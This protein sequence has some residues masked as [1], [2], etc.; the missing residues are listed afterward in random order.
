MVKSGAGGP[1]GV[2]APDVEGLGADDPVE[3]S[4]DPSVEDDIVVSLDPVGAS[5][6]AGDDDEHAAA[7]RPNAA[8][9]MRNRFMIARYR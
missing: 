3:G 7:I 6:T 9:R 1:S 8:S 4:V 5:V 2:D